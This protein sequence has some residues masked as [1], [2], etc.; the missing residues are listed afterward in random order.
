MHIVT[1]RL[2]LARVLRRMPSMGVTKRDAEVLLA[3]LILAVVF[4]I[5]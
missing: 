3:L 4:F 5:R 2:R 1:D